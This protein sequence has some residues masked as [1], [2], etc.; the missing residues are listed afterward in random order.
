M[1]EAPNVDA[2]LSGELGEWL[3]GQTQL[4]EDTHRKMRRATK[5]S[6]GI[7][8]ALSLLLWMGS[9]SFGVALFVGALIA[10]GGQLYVAYIRDPVVKEIKQQMNAR[11]AQAI[12]C[13][14]EQD[15]VAGPEFALASTYEMFPSFDRETFEDAW[16][17]SVG[18]SP[19]RLHE[20]HLEEWR[21][22]GKNRRLETVFRGVIMTV[23][24]T[25]QFLGSTL[26]ER[27]GNHMTLFG[28]RDSIS[29]EGRKLERVKMVDPRFED[30]FTIWSTDQV[31]ARYL[32]HPAY[33][34]RLIAIEQQFAGK[35]IRALFHAGDLVIVLESNELFESGSIDAAN[36]RARMETTIGQITSLANLA[37]ALNERP[38]G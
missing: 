29:I 35:D 21:Q 19:F 33:V 10:G 28:M 4:R 32:V 16:S 8:V 5:I 38:R 25:R 37:I 23:G 26:I 1:I 13:T 2:L 6:L 36:D 31:E 22:S 3:R 34:E 14:F 17:G 30:D 12:G 20:V 27:Q 9:G 11:I 24:F 7:A 18:D 15:A